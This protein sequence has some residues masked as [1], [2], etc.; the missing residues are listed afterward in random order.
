[1]NDTIIVI[2][3]FQAYFCDMV[4]IPHFIFVYEQQKPDEFVLRYV[5]ILFTQWNKRHYQW[6]LLLYLVN[7]NYFRTGLSEWAEHYCRWYRHEKEHI[8]EDK[9]YEETIYP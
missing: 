6:V 8:Q 7:K 4:N 3:Q 2:V 9:T 1:M 5:Q